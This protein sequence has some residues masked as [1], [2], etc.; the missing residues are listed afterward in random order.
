MAFLEEFRNRLKAI[1]NYL[2]SLHGKYSLAVISADQRNAGLGKEAS[3]SIISESN[4]ASATQESLKTFGTIRLDSATAE[5]QTRTNNDFGRE[6]N[7]GVPDKDLGLLFQLRPEL[8]KS[9]FRGAK[10]NVH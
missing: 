8:V 6:A 4:F 3:N 10:C 1:H 2:S 7:V 9:L 5:C